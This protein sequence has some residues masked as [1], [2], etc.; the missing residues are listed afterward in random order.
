ML[1]RGGQQMESA[2][3]V[4]LNERPWAVDRAIDMAFRGEM[5]HP[6]G[7]VIAEDCPHCLAVVEIDLNEDVPGIVEGFFK[8][9]QV[10]GVG[11]GVEIDDLMRGGP[12]Q[13]AHQRRADESRPSGDE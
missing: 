9:F 11:Q 4:G 6:I 1:Q 7:V 12:N 5:K 3:N 13:S 10:A 8:R 2:S